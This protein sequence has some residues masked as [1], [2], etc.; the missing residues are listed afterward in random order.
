MVHDVS[1]PDRVR[2][3]AETSPAQAVRRAGRD[4]LVAVQLYTRIPVTGRVGA[5]VGF[6]PAT[7][8][9]AA[10]HLPL[11][12][13]VVGSSAAALAWLVGLR[14]DA[15]VVAV[16]ATATSVVLTGAFH[17]DG[18]A[19]TADALGG[20]VDRGRALEIM[21]DS[22]LGSYGVVALVLVLAGK[23]ALLTQA[24][25]AGIAFL[26]TVLVVAH[27][28]SRLAPLAVMAALPYVGALGGK[29]KPM[30]ERVTTPALVVAVAWTLP[31]ALLAAAVV[32]P[33]WAGGA[34][35]LVALVAVA[36]SRL[37]RRRLGGFTGD[38]LGATQQV[39][40]LAVL[41]VLCGSV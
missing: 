40:E 27:V 12:G 23:V 8:H 3:S 28:V 4:V 10:A 7:L 31:A 16:V 32:G 26:S 21:T 14:W 36:A 1:V 38:T 20:P 13:W 15:G 5:W 30:A 29:A 2:P 17:E 34:V 24:A 35:V 41:A 6:E 22:R 19:D 11:V 37:L 25:A 18:L 39:T 33:R 9:R